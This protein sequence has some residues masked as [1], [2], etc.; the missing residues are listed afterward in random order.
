MGAEVGL[1]ES[2]GEGRV[3]GQVELRVALS[4]VFDDGDVDCLHAWG[5]HRL[6]RGRSSSGC[7]RVPCIFRVG[8]M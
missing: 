2:D 8:V 6:G 3:G 1:G 5:Q 4:P 7:N